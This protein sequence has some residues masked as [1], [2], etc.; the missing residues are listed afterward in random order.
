PDLREDGRTVATEERRRAREAHRRLLEADERTRHE[1]RPER[2]MLLL[3]DT[4]GRA[5]NR[6]G[7]ELLEG[8]T[9]GGRDAGGFELRECLAAR[10]AG[11]HAGDRGGRRAIGEIAG[12]DCR[13]SEAP[14]RLDLAGGA[15]GDGHCTVPARIDPPGGRRP[16]MV[17]SARRR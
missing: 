3:D 9:R 8:N 14:E 4:T 15:R 13:P 10:A 1:E 2:R 6:I 12:V 17:T 5:Q 11:E 16:L 7:E